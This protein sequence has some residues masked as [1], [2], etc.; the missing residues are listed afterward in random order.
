MG[1]E[2]A[3]EDV[4]QL[5][6]NALMSALAQGTLNNNLE[7]AQ[8]A[9]QAVEAPADKHCYRNGRPWVP[10]TCAAAAEQPQATAEAPPQQSV[11]A[12]AAGAPMSP[13]GL[14]G[15][16]SGNM[17]EAHDPFWSTVSQWRCLKGKDD[18]RRSTH[19]DGFGAAA[20]SSA[21]PADDVTTTEV[22]L[23]ES[24]VLFNEHKSL[25]E[26]N[27][28]LRQ[29]LQD[30]GIAVPDQ[31]GA[32]PTPSDDANAPAASTTPAARQAAETKLSQLVH[33]REALIGL[34][35]VLEE[36]QEDVEKAKEVPDMEWQCPCGWGF[37]P[38]SLFCRN[39]GGKRPET[40]EQPTLTKSQGL[41]LRLRSAFLGVVKISEDLEKQR[42]EN[43]RLRAS[44]QE[45]AETRSDQSDLAKN[46]VEMK[47][48]FLRLQQNAMELKGENEALKLQAEAATL[49]GENEMLRHQEEHSKLQE[50]V[51]ALEANAHEAAK[52]RRSLLED[53]E[54]LKAEKEAL[55]R[56]VE[57]GSTLSPGWAAQDPM[58]TLRAEIKALRTENDQLKS[59]KPPQEAQQRAALVS[60]AS[61]PALRPKPDILDDIVEQGKASASA[62]RGLTGARSLN[63]ANGGHAYPTPATRAQKPSGLAA[64]GGAMLGM[65]SKAAGLHLAG[66]SDGQQRDRVAA[67]LGNFFKMEP[68]LN[69]S[70]TKPFSA[71]PVPG[72]AAGSLKEVTRL[73]PEPLSGAGGR[74]PMAGRGGPLRQ[75]EQRGFR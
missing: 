51:A 27:D 42:E 15:T 25:E 40:K 35:D 20:T 54:H 18:S 32:S 24:K 21:A 50:Q 46:L 69:P 7:K 26:E 8:Q 34:L 1:K 74:S 52:E 12:A 72:H 11:A 56:T 6:R 13:S 68:H 23:Q 67:L 37:M 61:V 43:D 28:A 73:R 45:L 39:C 36:V 14:Y 75:L 49:R 3:E 31:P 22:L 48:E 33:E 65:P 10:D 9:K 38:D 19:T 17:Y 47:Q 55:Q 57:R 16:L 71:A 70:T 29:E 44:A 53:I 62:S 30:L 58:E 5:T 66:E 64:A 4:R 59:Q 2:L 60:S 41:S 63:Q